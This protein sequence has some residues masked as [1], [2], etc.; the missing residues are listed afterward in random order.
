[1]QLTGLDHIG[2]PT[3]DVEGSKKFY[4][5]LGF[6]KCAEFAL[7][8]RP[9]N[10]YRAGNLVVEFVP[11]DSIPRTE[12]AVGHFAVGIKGI[13][14]MYAFCQEKGIQILNDRIMELPFWENGQKCFNILGPNGEKIEF[15]E[16]L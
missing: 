8:P 11:A 10:F 1:M 13:E 9:F 14:E 7:G 15:V 4:E 2:I 5:M 3:D 6:E 12:G 16:L